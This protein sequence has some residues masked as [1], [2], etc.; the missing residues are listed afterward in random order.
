MR[1]ADAALYQAKSDGKDRVALYDASMHAQA[2]ERLEV[3]T[4]LR[5]GLQRGEFVLFY[6]PE[7]EVSGGRIVGMEALVRWQHP[8]RG[9]LLPGAFIP[10]AEETGLILQLGAWV[11]DEACRQ[12]A[13]WKHTLGDESHFAISVNISARQL[14]RPGLVDLV[15]ETLRKHG[16]EPRDLR[17]EI[18]ET[19]AMQNI[20]AALPQMRELHD[21]GIRLALDDFGTGYSSLSYL[22][23][24]P[25]DV[26]KLDRSFVHDLTS[27]QPARTIVRTLSIL[28]QLMHIDVTAEGIENEDELYRLIE[29]GCRWGQGNFFS[30]PQPAE[31]AGET[32][33]RGIRPE[34]QDLL[35]G[36][37]RV[38]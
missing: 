24:V 16:L 35:Q 2:L 26:L 34:V 3:E 13:H 6:Q 25:V 8:E 12:M 37:Q 33:R 11:L 32:L 7:V 28:A 18:T 23:Q 9:L 36:A 1:Q 27:D 31:L 29:L 10:V 5:R 21:L 17:L 30:E 4:G 19:A 22:R 20:D 38:A 14:A 15:A